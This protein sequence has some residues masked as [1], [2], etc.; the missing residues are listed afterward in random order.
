MTYVLLMMVAA[1]PI[2]QPAPRDAK[3]LHAR[4][5]TASSY[6]RSSWNRF[7]EN[8]LPLYASDDNP[9]TA[10]VEGVKGNGEGQWLL[11]RGPKLEGAGKL[12]IFIRNGYQKSKGLF[13]AN[14]RA[15]KVRLHPMVR[16]SGA[17]KPT[18]DVVTV[19]LKDQLAFQ[20]IE[21]PVP[22]RIDGFRLDVVTVYPGQKYEDLCISDIQ[23]FVVGTDAYS[24]SG[25]TAAEQ[26][27]Q[28]FAAERKQAAKESKPRVFLHSKYASR[29][30]ASRQADGNSSNLD[31][32]E[33]WLALKRQLR[34]ADAPLI[35]RVE[36]AVARYRRGK[37]SKMTQVVASGSL[38]TKVGVQSMFGEAILSAAGPFLDLRQSK[39][40]ERK[41]SRANRKRTRLFL[42]GGLLRPKSLWIESWEDVGI[43]DTHYESLDRVVLF[44]GDLADA[45]IGMRNEHG[46][47]DE[48]VVLL[49]DWSTGDQPQLTRLTWVEMHEGEDGLS[50]ITVWSPSEAVANK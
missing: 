1:G 50:H 48:L 44:E 33:V 28:A 32:G 35:P 45:V 39:F 43:R 40:L 21:L 4:T 2:L 49:L 41:G 3:R 31:E 23:V 29:R 10:W 18:G 38:P 15:K 27:I 42:E 16:K 22:S 34:P 36:N 47:W 9:K 12:R 17:M 19:A 11:W 30:L 26:R 37:S 13:R 7:D 6:L 5:V 8:Y 46:I 25:E 24:A 14:A 20:E